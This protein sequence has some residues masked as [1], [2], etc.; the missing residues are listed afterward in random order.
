MACWFGL[1]FSCSIIVFI[2]SCFDVIRKMYINIS[3]IH[4]YIY[5][6]SIMDTLKL[7]G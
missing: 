6:E 7:T 2:Y 5:Q 4:L 1:V 3:I